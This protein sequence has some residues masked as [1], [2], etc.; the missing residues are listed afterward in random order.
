MPQKKN[1]D[2]LELIRGKSGK[3]LGNL[4]GAMAIMKVLKCPSVTL[5]ICRPSPG[6]H[7]RVTA[8]QMPSLQTCRL[9]SPQVIQ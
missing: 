8:D 5:H 4:S 3:L 7:N 6:M 9:H 2:A 1:P